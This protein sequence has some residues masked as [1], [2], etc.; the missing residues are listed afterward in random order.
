MPAGVGAQVLHRLFPCP[1]A[2]LWSLSGGDAGGSSKISA[3]E[4]KQGD[5]FP[6]IQW[7]MS[8]KGGR[9]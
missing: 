2:V 7:R 9:S 4:S 3:V 6:P 8:L 1:V 5:A